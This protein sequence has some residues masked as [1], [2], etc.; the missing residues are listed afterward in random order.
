M[1]ASSGDAAATVLEVAIVIP[2]L[3]EA[4]NIGDLLDDCAAQ[5][6]G[7]A[8][9]VVVD[10]GST[11][12]TLDLLEE[13]ARS[14]PALRVLRSAR[15][16]PGRGRNEGIARARSPL[17]AT[18]DAGSRIGPDW[19]GALTGPL[20]EEGGERRLAVGVAEPDARTELERAV[21]WFSLRA[22]KPP[23]RPGPVGAAFLPAGRCGFAFWRRAWE[24]AGGYP[25]E[26]PWGEDKAFVKRLRERG[27]EVVLVPDAVVRWR[28]RRS[29]AELYRQYERYGR[30]DAMARL[31]RQN[32][33]VTL[34][35]YGA[36]A[37][38][39]LRAASGHRASA[40]ALAAA[41]PAYLG[42]FVRAARRE[43]G[44]GRAVAWVPVIR[45]VVDVAKMRG[46]LAATLARGR[47]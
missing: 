20:R 38:L 15:A 25:P 21:G 7:P 23:G 47:R 46:F 5:R 14:W 18:V 2:V 42:L 34:A 28:P 16:T 4:D 19:L 33:L 35:L 30:G 13:R 26:L 3:D 27:A 10:A 17:I 43:L 41:V 8:E 29:L 24:L 39:A 45:L 6:Q 31:D 37:L 32:E 11:D 9:V 12:G 22:F 36:A 44:L 40:G 1:T